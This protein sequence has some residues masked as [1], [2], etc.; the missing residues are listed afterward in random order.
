MTEVPHVIVTL[1]VRI[2]DRVQQGNSADH[3]PPKWF[4]KN[5]ATPVEQD[6]AELE[7]SLAWALE[8][9]RSIEADSPFQL[10]HA[11]YRSL[12]K[13]P[14]G[15]PLLQHF[16][17]SL[18]ERAVLDAFCRARGQPLWRLLREDQ[19][20]VD[21]GLLS[22]E[23][24]GT[25]P[26]DFLPA[27]PR[28]R[29]RLRH[30]VGLADPLTEADIPDGERLAD[31]LPQS[32]EAA[33]RVFGL[34][35]LKIKLCGVME[36]DRPRLL[37]IAA[38]V[39]QHAPAD[40]RCSIDGNEQ[41]ASLEDFRRFGDSIGSDARLAGLLGRLSF[42]EQ[43]LSRDRALGDGV[44]MQGIWP[45]RSPVIIDE[46]DG[47]LGDLPRALELGY[48]GTSHK[49]CK[50]VFKGIRNRCLLEHR[51]RQDPG[52][53]FLMTGEDLSNIGPIALP[54]D[55]A[56]QAALGIDSVERNGHHYFRGLSMFP[57]GVSDAMIAAHPDLYGRG[58]DGFAY[59][60]VL[61]GELDL[62]SVNASPFGTT[63]EPVAG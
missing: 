37:Q 54:Q 2:G 29:I 40:F 25:R 34:R 52:R 16:G 51:R 59:L 48:A 11:L 60:K 3:L 55:L 42:I 63:F 27:V 44:D 20:G 58:G 47:A 6:V 49:N 33:F 32:L 38:L 15:P 23:L 35:E 26:R 22:P 5:P 28:A 30:T 45:G 8:A 10:W 62:T 36:T 14:A 1:D 9:A 17:V 13:A 46:S 61:A 4:V 41:F 43:P 19:L 18:V 53:V 12:A 57:R 50:G 31:G 21:L 24:A 56:V 39:A 7:A